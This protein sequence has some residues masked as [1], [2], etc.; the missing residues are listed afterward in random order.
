MC[1]IWHGRMDLMKGVKH[2]ILTIA[3][4]VLLAGG[5]TFAMAIWESTDW[6]SDGATINAEYMQNNF[7][8]LYERVTALSSATG[9]LENLNCMADQI[10]K[11]NGSVW[12]CASDTLANLVC[13]AGQIPK[14][15]GSAWECADV[16]SGISTTTTVTPPLYGDSHT[17]EDCENAG[18]TVKS[19]DSENS[20]C[21]FSVSSRCPYSYYHLC[22][23]KSRPPSW[24]D[25]CPDGWTQLDNWGSTIL[26]LCN[27]NDS[28]ACT[29][30]SCLT[31][32]HEFSDQSQERCPYVQAGS[33]YCGQNSW[34]TCYARLLSKGCY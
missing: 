1:V 33:S 24:Y 5:I 20:L 19:I 7:D 4:G 32:Q 3:L 13:T 16:D 9:T 31:G 29:G 18:G 6:I 25:D 34:A 17:N 22:L 30:S 12:E 26:R 14:Y 23:V 28:A 2:T 10:A 8:Y 21:E 11:Y 15:S 27:G